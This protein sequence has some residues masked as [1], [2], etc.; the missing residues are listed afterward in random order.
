LTWVGR[1]FLPQRYWGPAEIAFRC[2]DKGPAQERRFADKLGQK[3][4]WHTG[5]D[6][7]AGYAS[8]EDEFP[9]E[10]LFVIVLSNNTG[11]TKGHATLTI[12]GKP[13]TFPANAARELV[14]EL[15][16]LYFTGKKR[17]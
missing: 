4:L 10:T 11:L 7:S 2:H 17:S 5:A 6:S 12:E 15:E 14:E 13:V 1:S 8:L 16:D 3:L 9:G